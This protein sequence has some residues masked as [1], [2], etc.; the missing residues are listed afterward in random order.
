MYLFSTTLFSC[1]GSSVLEEVGEKTK[2]DGLSKVTKIDVAIILIVEAA[3]GQD[4][5]S[6]R[7]RKGCHCTLLAMDKNT[8]LFNVLD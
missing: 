3:A 2:E 5:V 4:S 7:L 1:K 6:C 8:S